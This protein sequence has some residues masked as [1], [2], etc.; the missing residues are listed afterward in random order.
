MKPLT[1]FQTP[2]ETADLLLKAT[3]DDDF[4]GLYAIGSDPEVWA[5][6]S[7]TDRYTK[8]KFEV[9]F[10]GGLNNSLGAYTLVYKPT[11]TIAGFTRYYDYDEESSSVKIGY[12]FLA[13]TFW[14]TG[15]NQAL[16]ARMIAHAFEFCDQVIFEVYE[17]NLRSQRAVLKLGA[18]EIAP[19][20][21][22]KCFSIHRNHSFTSLA[23]WKSH[24]VRYCANS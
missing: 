13:K 8:E 1:H 21:D 22:R 6:H 5:L 12:T 11:Q 3:S 16:K 9:Y 2:L 20:G 23:K 15:L 19:K 24:W 18:I 17:F 7:D 4:E 10:L 14:G